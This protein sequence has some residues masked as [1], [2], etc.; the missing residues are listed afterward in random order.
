MKRRRSRVADFQHEMATVHSFFILL[1]IAKV[2]AKG[3]PRALQN[4]LEHTVRSG[5]AL[6]LTCSVESNPPS[7]IEWQKD[8]R[9]IHLGWERFRV[10]QDHALRIRNISF[11]DRGQYTCKA[12]NGFGS[13]EIRHFVQFN[14]TPV[15]HGSDA[16][17]THLTPSVG[18]TVS[19]ICQTGSSITWYKNGVPFDVDEANDVTRNNWSLT[20]RDISTEDSGIYECMTEEEE[21]RMKID[22][23]YFVEVVGKPTF[24]S[25]PENLTVSYGTSASFVCHVRSDAPAHIQW[26]RRLDESDA[27]RRLDAT[28]IGLITVDDQRFV[29]L[30]GS[31]TASRLGGTFFS[32]LTIRQVRDRD[33]GMYICACTNTHGY[34]FRSAFLTIDDKGDQRAVPPG[35]LTLQKNNSSMLPL[36]IVLAVL[37]VVL[38]FVVLSLLLHRTQFFVSDKNR[39]NRTSSVRRRTGGGGAEECGALSVRPTPTANDRRTTPLGLLSVASATPSPPRPDYH[40][41]AAVV[42]NPQLNED[43]G[44]RFDVL[45]PLC[46][47]NTINNNNNNN[48]NNNNHGRVMTL[49]PPHSFES[50]YSE[51]TSISRT[52]RKNGIAGGGGF[53]DNN[54]MQKPLCPS[55]QFHLYD[56]C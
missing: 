11:S 15:H 51:S 6:R 24:V 19:L 41:Y 30:N 37:L 12:T 13:I 56:K 45:R 21:G 1:I 26:L 40:R 55:I 8:G 23:T 36:L 10:T 7:L 5:D 48:S 50:V 44:C 53:H 20:L 32:K 17:S 9:S 43:C 25:P 31:K 39:S 4:N 3:P 49:H 34:I 22:K 46:N 42:S 14:M 35:N 54:I 52:P 38:L 28:K 47:N 29:V 18:S 33:A 2:A 27:D 16:T